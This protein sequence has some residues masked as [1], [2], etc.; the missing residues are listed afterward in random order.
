MYQQHFNALER[1]DP[2]EVT[3]TPH[4]KEK[5]ELSEAVYATI[6]MKKKS[7]RVKKVIA[8]LKFVWHA[9]HIKMTRHDT[10]CLY[11]HTFQNVKLMLNESTFSL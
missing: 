1:Y 11:I 8:S 6:C 7:I 4:V 5:E 3:D 2:N 9:S 10:K